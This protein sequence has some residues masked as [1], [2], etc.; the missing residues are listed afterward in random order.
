LEASSPVLA[1]DLVV[2]ALCRRWCAGSP[3][4]CRRRDPS[5]G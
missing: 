1:A 4:A 5:P 2:W 3:P